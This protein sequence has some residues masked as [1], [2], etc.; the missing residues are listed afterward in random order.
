MRDPYSIL[1]VNKNADQ[2]EI[3]SAW[4]MTA[5]ALHP[6]QN[7]DDPQ[8]A[9]RFTEAGRAYDL[10]KDPDKRRLFDQ[11]RAR[12]GAGRGGKEKTFMEQ[13][14][15][16]ARAEAEARA[17]AEA[18]AAAEARAR[19]EAR[20]NAA[21]AAQAARS[22]PPAADKDNAAED[23]V[24]KIFG[25]HKANEP[26]TEPR[27]GAPFPPPPQSEPKVAKHAEEPAPAAERHGERPN[28]TGHEP[29]PSPA[30]EL[31][32]YVIKRLTG[33]VP[34]PEKAPDLCVDIPVSIED[35]LGR[36]NPSTTL[37]D[38]KLLGITMPDDARDGT[39]IRLEGHGHRLPSVKR[40][41]VVATLRIKPHRWYRHYG[42]DLLTYVDIDIE[43]AVLGCEAKV[44]T[45][46]GEMKVTIPPWTGSNYKATIAGRGLPKGHGMRGNL[47][48]EVRVLLWDRPDQKIIDLMRSLREGLYL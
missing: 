33:S 13:R 1:G 35:I 38:G 45:P 44:D 18:H 41:D 12:A 39:Q 42:Y 21:A 24:A 26:R 36:V 3:K 43:N 17:A 11:A 30:I 27:S 25:T 16:R 29:R 28:E 10:L 2:Q 40:G 47:I 32:T 19:A 31:I 4:R 37:P 48:A 14:A 6:D 20:A 46:D 34:P 15:E 23:V 7:P 8:A 9:S 5:K 22:E